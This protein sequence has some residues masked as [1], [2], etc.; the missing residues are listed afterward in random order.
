MADGVAIILHTTGRGQLGDG[1]YDPGNVIAAFEYFE[2][3]GEIML[4]IGADE[5]GRVSDIG[6]E[7]EQKF[8]T[9]L[10]PGAKLVD[11]MAYVGRGKV[12]LN[13]SHRPE[14]EIS[15]TVARF[16]PKRRCVVKVK[17]ILGD[18]GELQRAKRGP[19]WEKELI[20]P[21]DAEL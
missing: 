13:V 3:Q 19:E 1:D 12:E 6:S 5:R 18:F 10:L 20:L 11:V 9:V 8:R 4:Q 14:Q 21:N 16:D 7:A 15:A 2:E 17:R